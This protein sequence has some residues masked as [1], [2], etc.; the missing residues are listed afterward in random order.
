MNL[1]NTEIGFLVKKFD[2]KNT[3]IH[4]FIHVY[5]KVSILVHIDMCIFR[6]VC[7]CI[8]IYC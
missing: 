5:K 1:T 8:C 6:Y 3:G 7:L 2:T 4:S